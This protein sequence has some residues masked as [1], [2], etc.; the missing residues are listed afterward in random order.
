MPTPSWNPA[1]W[2]VNR[3]LIAFAFQLLFYLHQICHERDIFAG[4]A[5]QFKDKLWQNYTNKQAILLM[6]DDV[7]FAWLLMVSE[8]L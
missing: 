4:Y 3:D 1:V 2:T 5:V 7:R 8:F 6:K